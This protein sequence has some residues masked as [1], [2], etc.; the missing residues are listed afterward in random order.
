MTGECI[1][2]SS[3]WPACQLVGE[4]CKL[5]TPR[6]YRR[7]PTQRLPP[8]RMPSA[9][10]GS[11]SPSEVAGYSLRGSAGTF[12]AAGLPQWPLERGRGETPKAGIAELSHRLAWPR[13]QEATFRLPSYPCHFSVSYWPSPSLPPLPD[14][15]PPCPPPTHTRTHT[16]AQT[17]S[18][19]F[20]VKEM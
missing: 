16:H 14:V 12:Q 20:K 3:L 19:I 5:W 7:A 9:V 10:Q 11:G 6:V 13:N 2:F 1:S 15:L 4:S 18:F 8:R 17:H